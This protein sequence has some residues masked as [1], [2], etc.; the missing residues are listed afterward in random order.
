MGMNRRVAVAA[1]LSVA[2]VAV[3]GWEDPVAPAGRAARP[4]APRPA[5]APASTA[6][7]ASPAYSDPVTTI[8]VTDAP[9]APAHSPR[10]SSAAPASRQP[11]RQPSRQTQPAS[12]SGHAAADSAGWPP[13]AGGAT[14]LDDFY[15]PFFDAPRES[16]RWFALD[17]LTGAKA[18]GG[19]GKVSSVEFTCHFLVGDWRNVVEGDVQMDFEP[20]LIL[21]TDDGGFDN[22]PTLILDFPFDMSWVWRFQNGVSLEIGATPGIYGDIEAFDLSIFAIPMRACLYLSVI[23]ELAFRAGVEARPGWDRVIMPLAG[24][25]WE[26]GEMFY[27]EAGVPRSLAVWRLGPVNLY[28]KLEWENTT[29][30]MSGH[31][32]D[33]DDITVD[34]WRL[35][36]GLSVAVTDD[37]RIGFEVGLILGR[38]FSAET[39]LGESKIELDDTAYLGLTIG[40]K[41]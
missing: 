22:L 2:F 39:E 15:L 10:V 16:D 34:D 18:E 7:A 31:D 13:P 6:P 3:A 20:R 1:A 41:F 26:P 36:G 5:S 12:R 29:F 28:G 17:Y 38:E 27:L 21:F 30:A 37:V 23:P 4:S 25:A 9:A 14:R 40:A 35:G 19:G 11:S 33:P 32:G 24:L 8:P